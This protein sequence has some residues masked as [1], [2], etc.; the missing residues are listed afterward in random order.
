MKQK[1][2]SKRRREDG[3]R[4]SATAE[5]VLMSVPQATFRFVLYKIE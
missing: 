5:W 4:G 3:R 2:R 1:K